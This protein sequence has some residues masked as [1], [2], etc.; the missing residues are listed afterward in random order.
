MLD[1][2][3]VGQAPGDARAQVPRRGRDLRLRTIRRKDGTR[4]EEARER[5]V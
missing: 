3:V 4:S 2:S 5:V 1:E